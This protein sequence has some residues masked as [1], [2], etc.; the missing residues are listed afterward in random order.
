MSALAFVS[1][2]QGSARHGLF[3][4]VAEFAAAIPLIYIEANAARAARE[5]ELDIAR[6]GDKASSVLALGKIGH[7]LAVAVRNSPVQ[8]GFFVDPQMELIDQLAAVRELGQSTF[9]DIDALERSVRASKSL[10]T[11]QLQRC[12]HS[13]ND[14][15]QAITAVTEAADAVEA[16]IEFHD[17]Q[18]IRADEKDLDFAGLMLQ[19]HGD[20]ATTVVSLF[21]SLA[22][23][24][25]FSPKRD[26]K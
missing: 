22:T 13:L 1:R 4:V 10:S 3:G 24:P 15:R 23:S 14:L 26:P 11:R 20:E 6:A 21:D 8:E 9:V 12:L 5:L 7:E 18:C 19:R 25:R 16:A 2:E 17:E